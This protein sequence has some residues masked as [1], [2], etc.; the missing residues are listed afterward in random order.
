[1]ASTIDIFNAGGL[2]PDELVGEKG[3]YNNEAE[4]YSGS[5]IQE[6]FIS[7]IDYS[8][9]KN[10]VKFGSAKEYY[11]SAINHIS[12][13]YPYDG[14]ATEKYK[15]IDS[16]NSLEFHIF[17]NEIARAAG[18]VKL[19]PPQ[20]IQMYSNVAEPD[21]DAMTSYNIGDNTLYNTYIDFE[22]GMTFESWIKFGNTDPTDILTINAL[23]ESFGSYVTVPLLKLSASAGLFGISDQTWTYS[24]TGSID[25]QNWHHYAFRIST[26]MVDVFIDGQFISTQTVSLNENRK[27]SKFI[28]LGLAIIKLTGIVPVPSNYGN[29][30]VFTLG[31][32]NTIYLDEV[33]FWDGF[34]SNE[35]IGRFW[36]THV[37]GN[38]K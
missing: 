9:P 2:K 23:S 8:D 33:R 32:N 13:G 19:E 1:M 30:P 34:R 37:D 14:S 29:T 36:F 24:L 26:N 7:N 27:K 15:W 6:K 20:N 35:K 4:I 17:Q 10:F 3:F 28:P 31:G 18:S 5:I 11:T 22:D 21:A 38:E 16:L 25:W 12:N